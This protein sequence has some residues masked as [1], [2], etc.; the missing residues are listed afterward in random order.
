MKGFAKPWPQ[1]LNPA[2]CSKKPI[3]VGDTCIAKCQF[4]AVPD[5]PVLREQGLV[6][7]CNEQGLLEPN[8]SALKSLGCVDEVKADV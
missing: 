5:D 4:P 7:K 2:G 6:F 8:L 3:K 1:R